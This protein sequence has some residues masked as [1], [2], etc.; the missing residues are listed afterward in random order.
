MA[1]LLLALRKGDVI[2]RLKGLFGP[3]PF[4]ITT[5]DYTAQK[6]KMN[7]NSSISK[8]FRWNLRTRLK[9]KA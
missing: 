5:F 1:F 4:F 9:R 7:F 6:K 2:L 3:T 8:R